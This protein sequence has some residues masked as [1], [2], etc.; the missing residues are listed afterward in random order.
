MLPYYSSLPLEALVGLE[1]VAEFDCPK[2]E[3]WD[4]EMRQGSLRTAVHR[5]AIDG[6]PVLLISPADRDSSG[7]FRGDRIYGGSYNELEAYLFFCR[8]ARPHPRVA[9]RLSAPLPLLAT[10]ALAIG[11]AP[12]DTAAHGLHALRP[13]CA[14]P[15]CTQAFCSMPPQAL[16]CIVFA[17]DQ[18]AVAIDHSPVQPLG[19]DTHAPLQRSLHLCRAGHRW[20]R[21]A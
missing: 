9:Q 7:L 12:P 1:C 20:R 10:E 2:G 19:L 8:C 15:A 4:G 14:A 5:A 3:T 16:L 6:I 13:A 18:S 21:C 17:V 11:C